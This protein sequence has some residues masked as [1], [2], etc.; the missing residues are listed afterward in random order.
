MIAAPQQIDWHDNL[1]KGQCPTQDEWDA[2]PNE[3]KD[4]ASYWF[5][6]FLLEIEKSSKFRPVDFQQ[7]NPSLY[8]HLLNRGFYFYLMHKKSP[9]ILIR[10]IKEHDV[11][12]LS[13]HESGLFAMDYIIRVQKSKELFDIAIAKPN[14]VTNE[15]IDPVEIFKHAGSDL[16][17][18]CYCAASYAVE[19]INSSARTT[20]DFW[21]TSMSQ[22]EYKS[23]LTLGQLII[24]SVLAN[25]TDCIDEIFKVTKNLSEHQFKAMQ[26]V[27]Y[28]EQGPSLGE[29]LNLSALAVALRKKNVSIIK[30]LLKH[31]WSVI[32]VLSQQRG[33][34]VFG[35]YINGLVTSPPA[36][37]DVEILKL[38]QSNLNA[39]ER[40]R[41]LDHYADYYPNNW[42]AMPLVLKPALLLGLD[43][44]SKFKLFFRYDM[45]GVPAFPSLSNSEVM[46]FYK[47]N[48]SSIVYDYVLT[49]QGNILRYQSRTM[50]YPDEQ[51]KELPKAEVLQFIEKLLSLP[52]EQWNYRK[53]NDIANNAADTKEFLD[54]LGICPIGQT[55]PN[56]PVILFGQPYDF[57]S[58]IKLPVN[59]QGKRSCPISRREFS[60]QDLAAGE[61]YQKDFNEYIEKEKLKQPSKTLLINAPGSKSPA[62]QPEQPEQVEQAEKA[63]AP[64][65]NELKKQTRPPV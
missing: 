33:L 14:S 50:P 59:E 26:D 10:L 38:I 29:K 46:S 49:V 58:L 24:R 7:A 25:R 55:V 30:Q 31:H 39:Q 57:I 6:L 4:E 36:Q 32:D 60:L 12:L 52:F 5:I 18:R 28:T 51:L 27:H 19:S 22:E 16:Q 44:Q 43:W 53:L 47:I 45:N 65:D 3:E 61:A 62:D 21:A 54:N 41:L 11:D 35:F 13:D 63:D 2:L 37:N 23:L 20:A 9:D 17:W 8:Q 64:E 40:F 42:F 34:T 48:I 56:I 15:S 1:K